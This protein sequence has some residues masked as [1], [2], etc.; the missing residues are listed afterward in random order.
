MANYGSNT[1]GVLL[2][3][4]SGT[5]ASAVTYSTGGSE[6]RS[7]AA[8]DLTGGG[9]PDLVVGNYSSG[10]VGILLNKGNG[11]FSSVTTYSSGGTDPRGVALADFTGDGSL[12]VVVTN[13]GSSTI[14]VLLNK[15]NGTFSAATTFST[16]S[17]SGPFGVTVGDFNGDG[18]PD[19]AV[20]NASTNTVAV[21]LDTYGPGSLTLTTPDGFSFAVA[22]GVYG[23][24]EFVTGTG[25]SGFSGESN[26]FNGYGRLY[27]GGSLF[28]PTAATY[29]TANSGQSLILGSGTAAGL[30]V[31]REIT[32]PDTGSQD[33]ARTVDTFTNSTGSSITTTVQIIAN[34]GS[35]ADTTVFDTSNGDT[36]VDTSDQWIG[37]DGN[38]TPAIITYIDGPLSLQ[39]TSVTL[40]DGQ[41]QWTYTITVAAGASVNLAYFTIV[42]TTSTAAVTE[43]NALVGSSGFGGQAGAFLSTSELQSLANFAN[44]A[45]VLTPPPSPTAG[46]AISDANLFH[47]TDTSANASLSNYTATITWGDGTVSTVT[48]TASSGGQIVADANGGFNVLGSHVYTSAILSPVTLSVAVSN[49]AGTITASDSSFTVADAPLTAGALTTPA[50][51]VG[52]FSDV[53]VFHFSDANSYVTAGDFSAVIT[54]GDGTS[55]T[56]T[57]TASAGG[58]IVADAGGGFNVLGAHDYTAALSGATFGVQV[59]D[60][61]GSGTGASQSGF[62]VA[63]VVASAQAVSSLDLSAGTTLVIAAG[64]TLTAANGVEIG[65][66]AALEIESGGTLILS[67][68][69]QGTG[70]GH[71]APGRRHAGSR[72]RLHLGYAHRDRRRR[73]HGGHRRVQRHAGRQPQ[74]RRRHRLVDQ[75]GR[76]HVDPFRH[77]HL[78]GRHDDSGRHRGRDL[79]QRGGVGRR[80]DHRQRRPLDPGQPHR[81]RRRRAGRCKH[82]HAG[83]DKHG[84]FRCGKH[85]SEQVARQGGRRVLQHGNRC[86]N[87][88]SG[89]V[90]RSNEHRDGH[91]NRS[92]NHPG[93]RH[94]CRYGHDRASRRVAQHGNRYGRRY[95][96]RRSGHAACRRTRG[97]VVA[98]ERPGVIGQR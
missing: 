87:R 73:R 66:G 50:G 55:S 81:G 83:R 91:G 79:P 80:P 33:F 58:Q 6:P 40:S 30:T 36:T 9:H 89:H 29:S 48:S 84:N 98:A 62:S 45:T 71:R 94:A 65:S 15:G 54:W 31:S 39:P 44:T 82:H 86:D 14:G 12:D 4:G 69:V 60:D 34:L 67:S 63:A 38:G 1:V 85:D 72:R 5:F 46:T 93:N 76:R 28:S 68:L 7:L 41:L 26:A 42:A 18:K 10:T 3:T 75:D 49:G 47:F 19:V 88:R 22:A 20:T 59:S 27:V 13:S 51:I 64:G 35:G 37:T 70:A 96:S 21:L 97:N 2:N 23:T 17:S 92:R 95:D 25:S 16:G 90:G 43:A 57:G 77:Q 24:G 74:R 61:D 32:V 52:S 11:T 8:G 56:V 78:H 53:A